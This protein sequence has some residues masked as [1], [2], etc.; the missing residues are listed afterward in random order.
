MTLNYEQVLSQAMALPAEDRQRLI[1]AL[2][3]ST[4]AMPEYRADP[5]DEQAMKWINEHAKEYPG[6]WL[7]L[8]GY[9]L[10]AHGMDL[11]EVSA[12]AKAQGVDQPLL[13]LV[14]PP[15]EHPYIRSWSMSYS[16]E[17]PTRHV[18]P[19]YED[20]ITVIVFLSY[21]DTAAKVTS[22]LDT[23]AEYCVFT[24]DVAEQLGIP[25]ETGLK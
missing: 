13:H 23:G 18:Y 24:Q 21:G 1:E 2:S 11:K 15:R 16:L 19:D 20:G 7:A 3:E 4:P 8:D 6:E 9:R 22:K 5:K 12:A 17:F 14:E 25:L 10:L